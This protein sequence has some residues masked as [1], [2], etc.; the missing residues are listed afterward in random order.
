VPYTDKV[1]RQ[2]LAEAKPGPVVRAPAGAS[3]LRSLAGERT[4]ECVDVGANSHL[5]ASL[6]AMPLLRST[7]EPGEH[8]LACW[9]GAARQRMTDLRTPRYLPWKL[10]SAT[11]GCAPWRSLVD[12]G[13]RPCGE[14]APARREALAVRV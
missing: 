4:A 6:S 10:R 13:R 2:L 9:V 7:H 11:C 3:L 5:L 8:W 14:S 1:T 12:F